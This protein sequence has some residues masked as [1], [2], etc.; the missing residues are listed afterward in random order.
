MATGMC[1]ILIRH[2]GMARVNEGSQ[3]YLP[4]TRLSTSDMN[5]TCLYFPAAEHHRSLAGTQFSVPLRVGVAE[6]VWVACGWF[7][8][9]KTVTYPVLTTAAG[10]RTRDHRVPSPKP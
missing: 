5:H 1:V 2:S 8:R 10:K 3:F 9:P 4:P 6:L 7:S